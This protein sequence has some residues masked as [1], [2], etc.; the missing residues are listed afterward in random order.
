MKVIQPRARHFLPQFTSEHD[1]DL[2]LQMIGKCLLNDFDSAGHSNAGPLLSGG[3][4]RLHG[5]LEY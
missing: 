1:T 5:H 3:T 2:M 4:A